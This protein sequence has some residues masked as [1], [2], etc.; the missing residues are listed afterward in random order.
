MGALNQ[1]VEAMSLDNQFLWCYVGLMDIINSFVVLASL[2]PMFTMLTNVAAT[3]T[4]TMA[5]RAARGMMDAGG[6]RL[7]PTRIRAKR[8]PCLASKSC[9]DHICERGACGAKGLD[10]N[11]RSGPAWAFTF[12]N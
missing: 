3:P 4:A 1:C 11:G 5:S 8:C 10:C 7:T 6:I 9:R 12:A 2:K